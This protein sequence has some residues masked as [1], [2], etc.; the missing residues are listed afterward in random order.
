VSKRWHQ[1]TTPPLYRRLANCK[2]STKTV[3][4][5]NLLHVRWVSHD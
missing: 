2:A 1:V 3:P 5:Y 4:D